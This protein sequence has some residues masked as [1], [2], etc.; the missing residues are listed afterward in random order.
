MKFREDYVRSPRGTT[1]SA[2]EWERG[3][4]SSRGKTVCSVVKCW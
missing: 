3:K 2:A 4:E 1:N